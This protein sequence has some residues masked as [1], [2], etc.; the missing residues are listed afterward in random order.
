[1]LN[2]Y[3][4]NF[5][6]FDGSLYFDFGFRQ[7]GRLCFFP[8]ICRVSNSLYVFVFLGRGEF[9]ISFFL[10]SSESYLSMSNDV[11]Y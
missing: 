2:A 4:T 9:S 1:M 6:I 10:I 3:S 7:S 5:F 8:I 11:F